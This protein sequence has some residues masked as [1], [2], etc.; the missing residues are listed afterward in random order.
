MFS[1]LLDAAHTARG[2]GPTAFMVFFVY[3]WVVWACKLLAARRYRPFAGAPGP[4][5]VTVLV[6]VYREPEAVFRRA[7][8]SVAR[9]AAVRA[10][11]DRRRR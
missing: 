9:R 7:L 1:F 5:T 3:V 10:D 2:S 6:P 8:A 4:L 11:R